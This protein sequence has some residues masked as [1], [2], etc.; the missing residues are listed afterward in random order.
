MTTATILTL[1]RSPSE[2][3]C[4][5][6]LIESIRSFGGSLRQCPIRIFEA[7]PKNA[8]CQ[9]LKGPDVQ[10]ISLD[11]PDNLRYFF[12]DKVLACAKA[13]EMFASEVQS[14]IWIDPGCLII[15]SPDLYLLD[16]DF[17]AA[18]RPVHITNVG[19]LADAPLDSFWKGVYNQVGFDDLGST[20]DTFVDGQCIRSYFNSHAFSINPTVGLLRLWF[21]HFEA[22]VSDE[23]YQQRS[24]QDQ[25]HRIFLH[26]A[27]LSAL[28]ATELEP[29]RLRILPPEYNY[30]YN[31]HQSVPDDRRAGTL[32]DLVS[33][34]YEDRSLDPTIVDDIEIHQPLRSWLADQFPANRQRPD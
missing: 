27:V 28:L 12:A 30:P 2:K 17:D 24:C 32:N 11:L 3:A 15:T 9:I 7:D 21:E 26:Q 13:E 4:A 22:L 25:L 6:L 31:L 1:V 10:L 23:D 33:I 29:Q 16:P 18:V 34:T 5:Q 8:S 14:L 20:V 19:L